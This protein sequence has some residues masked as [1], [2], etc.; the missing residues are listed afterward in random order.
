MANAGAL[1]LRPD[2]LTGTMFDSPGTPW[3]IDMQAGGF[4]VCASTTPTEDFGG[5]GCIT[6]GT[7]AA[8]E[9]VGALELGSGNPAVIVVGPLNPVVTRVVATLTDG[10]T[11]QMPFKR[12]D[13]RGMSA[14]VLSPGKALR[15]MTA[16][17]S[18][19]SVFAH[20]DWGS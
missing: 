13:G 9:P 8:N 11:V 7:P 16:Y 17:K 12:I 20:A 10:E 14:D 15:A 2:T 19:G 18:D 4:G 3:T 1:G 5:T 6:P